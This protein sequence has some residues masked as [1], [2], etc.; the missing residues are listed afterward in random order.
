MTIFSRKIGGLLLWSALLGFASTSAAE[1]RRI[2][3]VVLEGIPAIQPALRER[4]LQYLNVRRAVLLSIA[5]DG[6]SLLIGTR[7]GESQQVHLV[8]QP[9]GARQ[10]LTFFDEPVGSAQF[11]PGTKGGQIVFTRQ[12][13][14]D[15]KH[16]YYL[17]DVASG[18]AL[19]ITD[20]KSR[21]TQGGAISRDGALLA[22]TGTVRNQKDFDVL[23]STPVKPGGRTL[24]EVNDGQ[25]YVGEF[26]PAGQ[27]LTVLRY[28]SEK[29]TQW[30]LV[31][32][33]DG[34]RTELTPAAPPFYYGGG[35]WSP[36]GTTLYITSDREGEFRKLYAY[37]LSSKAWRCL[38]PE[39]NWDVEEIAVDPKSGELAYLVNEDGLSALMLCDA[40]GATHR[41]VAGIPAG[42]IGGLRF[43]DAGGVLGFTLERPT[44]PG[45][46]YTLTTADGKL[47][48][49]TYS[50]VGGLNTATF[51][52]P[53]LIRYPTF[54]QVE[55]KPRTIPAFV[56][57][58]K[59]E[60][61]RPVVISIHGGPESQYQ[62][63]FSS[64]TQFWAVELGITTIAPNIRGS[65][66]YG[67][68]FHQLDN[69]VKREDAVK[70]IG[71]LLDWIKTQPDMDSARVAIFGGSYG[72]YAV[73]AGLTTYPERFKAGIDIVGIA[74]FTSFLQNTP[75]FRRDLRREEYG[76]ERVPEVRAVLER[77]SP[78]NHAEK[79]TASLF[80]AHGKNDPRVPVSEAQQ[81]V[82]KMRSLKR[83]VWFAVAQNEGHGFQKKSNTDLMAVLYAMFWQDYLLGDPKPQTAQ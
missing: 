55:G 73:L 17:L 50:E 46:V 56:F 78:L 12:T 16:Q 77:I 15:E 8:T 64:G 70:D 31:N 60:G 63:L 33:S 79:I 45:D 48:R 42:V 72:G 83:P 11:V 69:G 1:E 47:T 71:A 67:R 7:F 57:P 82:E 10:Q 21:H 29:E 51:V 59:G 66:G 43:A 41:K 62:P 74:S 75:E 26:D 80:V 44:N 61:K 52:E 35:E 30:F 34:A 37:D 23:L 38:T 58:G 68:T 5:E 53:K 20:G 81:I 40:K 27:R 76:D 19:L 24:L 22:Y 14:G 3:E 2:G 28:V 18:K 39:L 13:G 49:W 6:Q 32:V 25:Y 54:D 65:T 36:D 4:M 9:G